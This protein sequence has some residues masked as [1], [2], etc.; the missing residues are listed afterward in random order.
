MDVRELKANA[1]EALRVAATL[2]LVY[3]L[4]TLPFF[5]FGTARRASDFAMLGVVALPV[6]GGALVVLVGLLAVYLACLPFRILH[7]VATARRGKPGRKKG[8]GNP[9]FDL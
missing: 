8:V 2:S 4:A 5:V 1:A 7:R 3:F 6:F 9:D